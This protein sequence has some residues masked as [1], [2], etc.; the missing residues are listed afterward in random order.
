M[1]RIFDANALIDLANRRFELKGSHRAC[2]PDEIAEELQG[3]EEGRIW[4]KDQVLTA[5]GID[6]VEYIRAFSTYLNIYPHVSFYSMKGFGDVAVVATI[7]LLLKKTPSEPTL[8]KELFPW[9]LIYLVTDD[10]NLR[11]FAANRFGSRVEIQTLDEFLK[12]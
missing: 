10:R 3:R 8:S 7:D 12:G 1:M 11:R 6:E 9:N 5:S 2:I 4:L